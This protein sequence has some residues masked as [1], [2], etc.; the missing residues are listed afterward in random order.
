MAS[1]SPARTGTTIMTLLRRNRQ[2]PLAQADK[3][4]EV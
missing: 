2:P 4:R 1:L 3:V